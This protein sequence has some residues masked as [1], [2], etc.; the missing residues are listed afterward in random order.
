[1]TATHLTANVGDK[2]TICGLRD[3]KGPAVPYLL[4][5]HR[6]RHEAGHARVGKAIEFCADCLSGAVRARRDAAT[7]T[8]SSA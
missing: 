7:T 4:A 2:R 1:M 8:P 3:E 6:E 5:R